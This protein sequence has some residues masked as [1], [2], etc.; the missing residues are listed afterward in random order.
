LN[1]GRAMEARDIVTE[2]MKGLPKDPRLAYILAQAQRQVGDFD[3]AEA[4]ARSFRADR[5]ED[6][7]GL[8]LLAQIMDARGRHQE[9]IDLLTPEIARLREADGQGGQAALL[10][11]TV[12]LSYQQL[13]K[14]DQAI[15]AFKEAA[16]RAPDEPIRQV[17]LIQGLITANRFSEALAAADAARKKF[18]DDNT[19]LYQVGATQDRAGRR[20][21]AEKT[22]RDLIAR[23]PMDANALNYLGYMFAEHGTQ[24]DEAVQLIERALKV[25]PDNASYLDSLGWAYVQQGKLD[26]ADRPLST[27]AEKLPKNSVVQDHLGDL[28][29]KQNRRADAIAA[30][31]RALDG[32]G[33]SIDRA[34]IQ[35]KIKD[36]R[37]TR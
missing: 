30:W 24:L 4:T 28:R 3:A 11:D 7:R 1:A 37:N 9:V 25:D 15:A 26:L 19:V 18:P 10:L 35:K 22:F 21:D 27:A 5:P 17:L 34:K 12:A 6:V 8:Y 29:L 36:A 13:R 31:Q 14:P 32:D 33:D 2:A 16:D 23:D 20:T